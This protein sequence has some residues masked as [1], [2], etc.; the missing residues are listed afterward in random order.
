MNTRR[1]RLALYIGYAIV[2]LLWASWMTRGYAQTA[3]T[4]TGSLWTSTSRGIS[5]DTRARK[6]GDTVTI[7]V[8]E[9]TTATSSAATKTSRADS[10]AFGGMTG[11]F[12]TLNSILQPFGATNSASTSGSGQTSR[13]GSLSTQLSARVKE[14]LPNGNLLIEGTREIGVNAEK[15][16]VILSGE[17]R[18]QDIASDNTV[19]SVYLANAKV[20]YDGK[21]PVGEKQRRGLITTLLGWLF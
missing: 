15:Q 19:S 10:A 7:I 13:S 6:V 18:P 2:A 17:V 5:E 12:K 3:P 16:K 21:G 20:Q 1:K 8:S 9:T 4:P 11:G 14:I